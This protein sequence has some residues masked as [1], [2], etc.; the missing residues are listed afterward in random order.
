M[1]KTLLKVLLGYSF[2]L[3]SFT[4][5]AQAPSLFNFQGIARNSIGKPIVVD[6]IALRFTIRTGTPEGIM[7]YQATRSVITDS[8]GVFNAFVGGLGAQNVIGRIDTINWNSGNKY[9]QVEIDINNGTN[10]LNLGTTQMLSVPFALFSN[11]SGYATHSLYSGYAFSSG[12]YFFEALF[13]LGKV[14]EQHDGA[15]QTLVFPNTNYN[16]LNNATGKPVYD[17]ITGEFITPQAGIYQFD[18]IVESDYI[19]FNQG[20]RDDAGIYL[21]INDKKTRKAFI[22]RDLRQG[23]FLHARVHL[24]TG[25]KVSIKLEHD[26]RLNTNDIFFSGYKIN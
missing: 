10:F 24:E 3:I 1:F 19:D 18:L 4:S 15:T 6:S 17:T 11:T 13:P 23:A 21:Y 5:S 14:V 9:L 7:E 25:D 20:D 26:F 22:L 12:S 8:N 2:F 16:Q